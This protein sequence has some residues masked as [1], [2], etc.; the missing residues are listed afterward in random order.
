VHFHF[1]V[2]SSKEEWH[3]AL[4]EMREEIVAK[5]KPRYTTVLD[6]DTLIQKSHTREDIDKVKYRGPFYIDFD[7]SNSDLDTVIG[8][9][10]QFI[11]QL[12]ENEVDLDSLSWY[13]SGSRGFHVEVPV[14]LFTPKPS[15]TGVAQL[16]QIYREMLHQVYIDTMD[17]RVYSSRKGRQWRTPN[18]ER[19]N[20]KFKVPVTAKEIRE[21][22]A[23]DYEEL[24]S[25]PRAWP[26][27]AAPRLNNFLAVIYSKAEQKVSEGV[28]KR[29]SA[30]KDLNLLSRYKGDFPPTLLK[31][32]SGEGVAENAGF[33]SLALQI[34]VTANALGK[35]LEETL[36]ACEGLIANYQS[37]SLRYN[38][39]KKRRAEITRMFEYTQ[40]NV[41]YSYSIGAIKTLVNPE[42]DTGDLDGVSASAGEL[43]SSGRDDNDDGL[44][45]G[46]TM[47]ET[48]V[49]RWTEE[50]VAK[51]W[52]LSFRNVW[53]I[54]DLEA[55]DDGII[56]GYEADVYRKGELLGRHTLDL[57]VF[58]SRARLVEFSTRLQGVF[59]GDD[60][61]VQAIHGLVRN[62]ALKRKKDDLPGAPPRRRLWRRWRIEG[63][64]N[65]GKARFT[66]PD[67]RLEHGFR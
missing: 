48:G 47:R 40:D 3:E 41:C 30:Q 32:M 18:V 27:I 5:K 42:V 58:T 23:E 14:A 59:V 11:N 19:E 53:R 26:D 17:L 6:L 63:E 43:I 65:R 67:A 10:R 33:Q 44:L 46:L 15:K 51:L 49:Y 60:K 35:K 22:T 56:A 29:G 24:V 28:K 64:T 4:A 55:K 2:E 1:Q 62:M 12:E 8:K 7:G 45:G 36:A 16:P 20:G 31:L 39:P 9:V 50:G 61:Q 25:A 13:A 38:T 37:D 34:G 54:V 21:M 52:D 57:K 66:R